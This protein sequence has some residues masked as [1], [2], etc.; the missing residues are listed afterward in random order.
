MITPIAVTI[1]FG[2][3][4]ATLL[5]LLVIPAFI[6][7]LEQLKTRVSHLLPRSAEGAISGVKAIFQ[8]TQQ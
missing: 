2:L 7:L 1:C 8:G 4:F 3:A 6:L 5:I